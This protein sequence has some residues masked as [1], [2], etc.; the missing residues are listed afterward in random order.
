M[1]AGGGNAFLQQTHFV[2]QVR[3]VTHCG[4]HAAQ[5]GGNLRTA[6]VKRKMLSMNSSTSWF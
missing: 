6:C 2:R 3:L 1:T 5:Q 4:G